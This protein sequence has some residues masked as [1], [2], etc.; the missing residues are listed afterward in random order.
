MSLELHFKAKDNAIVMWDSLLYAM[1]MLYY[2]WLAKKLL[3]PI[4]VQNIARLEEIER[5]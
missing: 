4:A 2:H 1:H 3:W 5:E